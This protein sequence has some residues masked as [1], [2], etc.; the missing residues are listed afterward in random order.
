MRK[1]IEYVLDRLVDIHKILDNS[2]NLTWSDY[3]W[4]T[5]QIKKWIKWISETSGIK[6]TCILKQNSPIGYI[7]KE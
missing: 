5:F 6:K 1:K 2:R 7:T 3:Y 4:T